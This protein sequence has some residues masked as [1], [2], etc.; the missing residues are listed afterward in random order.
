MI[1]GMLLFAAC[2]DATAPGDPATASVAGQWV[3]RS[4][5][6]APL[7]YTYP[8]TGQTLTSD[9]I[10][11]DD[12]GGFLESFTMSYTSEYVGFPTSA[13][14]PGT[15]TRNGRSLSLKWKSGN[16]GY[17]GDFDGTRLTLRE[18]FGDAP[19]VYVYTR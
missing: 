2:G 19:E 9:V 10:G 15:Y 12:A 8:G 18:S 3:L 13:S 7:P 14:E 6:G 4:V 16:Y 5:N 1:A 11:M 17:T